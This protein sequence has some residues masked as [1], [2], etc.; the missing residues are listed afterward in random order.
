MGNRALTNQTN[1]KVAF[2]QLHRQSILAFQKYE[3]PEKKEL[4]QELDIAKL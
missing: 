4:N 1:P 2:H 3:V